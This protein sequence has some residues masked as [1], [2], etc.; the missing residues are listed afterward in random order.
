VPDPDPTHGTTTYPIP[1][2]VADDHGW[3]CP[4]VCPGCLAPGWGS[5]TGPGCQAVTCYP[6]WGALDAPGPQRV[7]SH[8]STLAGAA[9]SCTVCKLALCPSSQTSRRGGCPQ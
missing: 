1:R 5:G 2:E 7:T 8:R 4:L 9:L 3:G 6:P